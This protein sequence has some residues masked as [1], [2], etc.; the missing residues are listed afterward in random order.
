M[1]FDLRDEDVRCDDRH[2]DALLTRRKQARVVRCY[3]NNIITTN[4]WGNTRQTGVRDRRRADRIACQ[5]TFVVFRCRLRID[6]RID[7][8]FL[9][10]IDNVNGHASLA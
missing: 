3:D 2:D 9:P 1:R 4:S 6:Q 7:F 10:L 8:L 5:L